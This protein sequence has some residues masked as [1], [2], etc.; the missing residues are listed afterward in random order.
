MLRHLALVAFFMPACALAQAPTA[1]QLD[2][3]GLWLNWRSLN[4][5]SLEAESRRKSAEAR[6]VSEAR[7]LGDRVGQL[8]AAGDC[9]GGERMAREAGDFPL[10]DAVRQYCGRRSG[11]AS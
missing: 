8:V 11:T 9:D 5:A 4:T 1:G 7:S 3:R 10:V 6:T 2:S